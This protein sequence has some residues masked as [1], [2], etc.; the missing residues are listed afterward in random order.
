MTT[1]TLG[2]RLFF[3]SAANKLDGSSWN[4]D[5]GE[6]KNRHYRQLYLNRPDSIAADLRKKKGLH[7]PAKKASTNQLT[8]FYL[9]L[10]LYR[11]ITNNTGP[12]VITTSPQPLADSAARLIYLRAYDS[13]ATS[14][15]STPSPLSLWYSLTLAHNIHTPTPPTPTL[16]TFTCTQVLWFLVS[17]TSS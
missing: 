17:L 16:F 6:G 15:K 12:M 2:S 11:F 8:R 4:S 13:R 10:S 5:C 14:S 7:E 1:V 9:Q 3:N